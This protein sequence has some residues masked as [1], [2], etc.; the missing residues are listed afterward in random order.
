MNQAQ[1]GQDFAAYI[2]K[3]KHDQFYEWL[4]LEPYSITLTANEGREDEIDIKSDAH[5]KT[6]IITGNFTTLIDDP[7]NP[8]TDIDDGTNHITIAFLDGSNEL[9]L[10]AAPIPADLLLTPGR[11]LSSLITGDPSNQLFYPFPFGHIFGAKGSIQLSLRNNSTTSNT[12]NLLF[13]GTKLLN[14]RIGKSDF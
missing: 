3:L 8:G 9:K 12:L 5:F 2:R 1:A 10:S 4:H 13:V 7:Q 6:Q 14:Q 11:V